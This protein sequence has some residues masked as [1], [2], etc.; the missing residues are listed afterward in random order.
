MNIQ[1]FFVLFVIPTLMVA[2]PPV[3]L[4]QAFLDLNHD[5]VAMCISA[6]PDDEDG[7]T[8]A[9]YRMKYG[10]K[11]YSVFFT[12]GEGGQ[13][14]KGPELYENLGV[15]RTE[16]TRMAATIQGTEAYFL[17]FMDFGFSKTATETFRK[18]GG[19]TEVLRRL[20]YILRKLKPDVIFTNLN[21]IDGHGHH[22]AVAIIAIAAFDA[23]AD[24]TLFPEQLALPGVTLW[25]PRK[26]F[27]RNVS[28][29][30]IGL[31]DWG[32]VDVVNKIEEVNAP[33]KLSYAEIAVNALRMHK[34]QGLDRANLQSFSR[35]QSRH[36]LI[37][38]N[39]LYE[40][41][42]TSFFGGIDFFTDASMK[43]LVPIRRG[44]S[45]I[46]VGM[47][48]DS[49]LMVASAI[50]Q[51]IEMERR[52]SSSTPPAKRLLIH[53][54]DELERLVLL[55]C[56][57]SLT[58]KLNDDVVVPGQKVNGVLDVASDNCRIGGV[59]YGFAIPTGWRISE[60]LGLTPV[61]GE[62]Q[63]TREFTLV[64]GEDPV[65]TLPKAKAQYR[66]I[67]FG[68]E[69]SATVHCTVS[70]YPFSFSTMAT[71]DVAPPQAFKVTP[72][73]T[74]I[75]PS[76]LSKGTT[77]DYSIKNYRPAK[78]VGRVTVQ[79]PPGWTADFPAYSIDKEDGNA[80]GSIAIRATRDTKAGE[81]RV[82]LK[83]EY[84]VEE[85]T[86]RVFD[87]A[88]AQGIKV[89]I[90]KSYDNTLESATKEMGV[91]YALLDSTM[92]EEGN[93]SKFN[94][95]VVDIRAYLV[96][97]D[98]KRN[99]S[100]LLEYVKDGG[101][102]VVTYQRPQ[103]WKPEYAPYPFTLS[104]KRVTSEDA[105]VEVLNPQHPL[106]NVPNKIVDDD[107]NDWKQERAMYFPTNVSK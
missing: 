71:F 33:R 12:R 107:W 59:K 72:Q 44:L 36:K 47:P 94:T 31:S 49:L 1:F 50:Q 78:T 65:L 43:S 28:R 38:S 25:Q 97:D 51:Q 61:I 54:Q 24:P 77:F 86:V 42:T 46:H 96:R 89:G 16:E 64:V 9:Y 34:T 66:P 19:Q 29:P 10:V 57:I 74:R 39:S 106:F 102:L 56:N 52:K 35:W 23:A 79:G 55:A 93:L 30:E 104:G 37:R 90:I 8:L 103:E 105:P 68:Q 95:I 11:T 14:E 21:P 53:W 100:H 41:D 32:Q 62:R 88:V 27:I 99:N 75:A 67:E 22:Q 7:A 60:V 2:Q 40:R 98:L 85:A 91:D 3:E 6:H 81:Y 70:G 76:Q 5:G 48:Q 18:W 20:V 73:V 17:N 13:N 101:N 45:S 80:N 26:S 63:Y 69:L 58:M 4:Q 87:V 84:A 92:L 82:R 15:L 83:T